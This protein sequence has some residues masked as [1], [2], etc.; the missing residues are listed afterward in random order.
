MNHEK[1][2]ALREMIAN[3]DRARLRGEAMV[4]I[5]LYRETGYVKPRL[6]PE[7]EI[8]RIIEGIHSRFGSLELEFNSDELPEG[9]ME[10]RDW[11]SFAMR[12]VDVWPREGEDED[13]RQAHDEV[14]R[15]QSEEE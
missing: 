9:Y 4:R 13:E 2:A 3:L 8:G 14:L 6:K 10:R 11:R 12:S 15:S 1:E 5:I 7:E